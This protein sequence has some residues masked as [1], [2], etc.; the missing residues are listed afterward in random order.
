MLRLDQG[1]QAG[2][3]AGPRFPLAGDDSTTA[4]LGLEVWGATAFRDAFG[5]YTSALESLLGVRMQHTTRDGAH[6]VL[7]VG[8]G[9]GLH[10]Q[11]GAPEWRAVFTVESNDRFD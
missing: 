4:V 10:S 6:T 7:K 9:E 2:I 8:F 1:E 3:A 11:F 5:K